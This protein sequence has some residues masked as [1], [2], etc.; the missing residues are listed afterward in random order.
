MSVRMKK[1][2]KD[3]VGEEVSARIG[4]IVLGPTRLARVADAVIEEWFGKIGWKKWEG[5]G[6]LVRPTVGLGLG[7]VRCTSRPS[8]RPSSTPHPLHRLLFPPRLPPIPS[9]PHTLHPLP[10]I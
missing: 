10:P 5:G 6:E 8:V 4:C 9:T 7:R 3:G 2:E 1:A